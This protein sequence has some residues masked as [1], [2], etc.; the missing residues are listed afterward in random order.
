[1]EFLKSCGTYPLE[2]IEKIDFCRE[3]F[4]T[5]KRGISS[6]LVSYFLTFTF[7]T[8]N[9]LLNTHSK[10]YLL[11]FYS[12]FRNIISIATVFVIG[13][14]YGVSYQMILLSNNI[15]FKEVSLFFSNLVHHFLMD[16]LYVY[17]IEP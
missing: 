16:Y 10:A 2:K 15:S 11:R 7:T 12:K 14:R 6:P 4:R 3:Y 1:M 9:E 8:S 17:L 13:G 5:V